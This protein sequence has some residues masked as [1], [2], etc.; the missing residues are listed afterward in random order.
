MLTLSSVCHTALTR[1]AP[2]PWCRVVVFRVSCV[3]YHKNNEALSSCA[4]ASH[5]IV[6][7]LSFGASD[8]H[9]SFFDVSECAF[10]L[11]FDVSDC[12]DSFFTLSVVT[13]V[14]CFVCRVLLV[15][16]KPGCPD[17]LAV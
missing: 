6:P 15:E 11:F 16:S 4:R 8:C 17:R 9:G 13:V 2:Y 12:A 3:T 1:S 10:A 14:L 5:Q 7:I